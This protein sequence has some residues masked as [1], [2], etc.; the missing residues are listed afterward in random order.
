MRREKGEGRR[1]EGR[2]E[3]EKWRRGGGEEK[4]KWRRRERRRMREEKRGQGRDSNFE[5]RLTILWCTT[6]ICATE[7][8]PQ[9][10]K[11]FAL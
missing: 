5:S 7:L 9:I 3:V 4:D 2:R 11:F 10:F 1:G 8:C 6:Y